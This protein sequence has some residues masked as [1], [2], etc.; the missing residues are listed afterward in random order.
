MMKRSSIIV[1][2]V[3]VVAIMTMTAEF[4]HSYRQ[5]LCDFPFANYGQF[6]VKFNRQ[7]YHP[8]YFSG[9]NPNGGIKFELSLGFFETVEARDDM[10]NQIYWVRY[11][12]KSTGA[13]YL[14]RS[15]DLYSYL[16]FP[17]GEYSVHHGTASTAVGDWV[18]AVVTKTGWYKGSFTI[19]REMV[20]QFPAIAVEPFIFEETP[21]PSWISVAAEHTNG[22][23]YRARIF[24]NEGNIT[25]QK[26]WT[27]AAECD[28]PA[29]PCPMTF[30]YPPEETG[31]SL[32]IET[33]IPGQDWPLMIPGQDCIADGMGPGGMSRVS[34]WIKLE[35]LPPPPP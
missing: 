4:G 28:D 14:L 18:I 24:D 26:R 9:S 11:T 20:E 2:L 12:N 27:P 31:K 16:G 19:T 32:R 8:G 1:A 21:M 22:V 3:A 35:P 5:S 33:R 23:E 15:P 6:E 10:V 34:I 13:N 7:N 29:F 30:E 17:T 25:D